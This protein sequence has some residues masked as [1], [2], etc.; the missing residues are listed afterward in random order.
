MK[1]ALIAA[2][3]LVALPAIAQAQTPMPGF[4][5]G[6]EGGLNW[7]MNFTVTA[8]TANNGGN[9]NSAVISVTP[10][11]GLDGWR[12]DRLRLRRPARRAWKAS[13][14]GTRPTSA[15]PGT[16]AQQPGRPAR[17]HGQPAV[18]L[19]ACFGD[20]ART[21]A[22][23]PASASSMARARCR[24]TV[25]AY[26]GIVGLAWNADTNFRVSLDGR[27]YGTSNP[28]DQR[29]TRWTNN[30]FSVMLGLQLKFGEVAGCSAAAAADRLRR[31]RSWCS[32]TGTA[33]T[34]RPRP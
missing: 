24:S 28:H 25:F 9:L 6:A 32:S 29:R 20:H 33:R 30:N 12:R 22:L 5:V 15:V 31:R 18:R 17:H 1:K 4:Y 14:A 26:Q 3:A 8:A 13:I 7:L 11:T 2:A 10:Q 16:G 21:S 27:Y 19:H 34:S 23:V